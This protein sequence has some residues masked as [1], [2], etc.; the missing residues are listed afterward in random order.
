MS[1][2]ADTASTSKVDKGE[3]KIFET[4]IKIAFKTKKNETTNYVA[5]HC[6]LLREMERQDNNIIFFDENLWNRLW[7]KDG[8]TTTI[9]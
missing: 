2:V 8:R 4:K 6:E 1:D 3:P 9:D 7:L 5:H